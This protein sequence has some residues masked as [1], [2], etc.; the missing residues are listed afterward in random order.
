MDWIYSQ[1]DK[2]WGEVLDCLTKTYDY[3]HIE[4]IYISGDKALWIKIELS[5]FQNQNTY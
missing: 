1:S 4:K 2:L 3:E 5:G